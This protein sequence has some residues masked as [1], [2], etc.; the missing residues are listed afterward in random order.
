VPVRII[1]EDGRRG[2]G[3]NTNI[4]ISDRLTDK[5]AARYTQGKGLNRNGE[6]KPEQNKKTKY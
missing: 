2:K 3:K 5:G 4:S 6:E 1:T